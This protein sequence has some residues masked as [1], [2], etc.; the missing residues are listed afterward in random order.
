MSLKEPLLDI[1]AKKS[2]KSPKRVS[3]R[4]II[5]HKSKER[6][7]KVQRASRNASLLDIKAKK[8]QEKS[9]ERFSMSYFWTIKQRKN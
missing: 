4:A 8:E 3:Q 7:R 6:T 1:K 5:G 9:K 2:R